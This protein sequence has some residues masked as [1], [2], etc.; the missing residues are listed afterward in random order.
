MVLSS[1]KVVSTVD[2]LA[3]MPKRE[4]QGRKER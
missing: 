2:A 3:L 4:A 1:R